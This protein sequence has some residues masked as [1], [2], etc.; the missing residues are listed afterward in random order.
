[1]NR[2]ITSSEIEIV[3]KNLPANKSPGPEGFAGKFCQAFRE[4]FMPTFLKLIPEV[5]E[6]R[7][8]PHSFCG[9]T[10]TLITKA[11]E[12]YQKK[13]KLQAMSPNIDAKILKILI[14]ANQIQQ[15]IKR[16]TDCDQIGFIPGMQGFFSIQKSISVIQYVTK[17]KTR[18]RF[19]E[20]DL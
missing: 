3:I 2:A 9:A 17:W 10:I 14:L 5:A 7:I 18:N 16:I 20:C 1:M 8:Y 15:H 19:L 4:E 11:R 6:E 13:L 12:R